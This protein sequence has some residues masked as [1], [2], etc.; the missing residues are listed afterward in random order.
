[1][2]LRVARKT[3]GSLLRGA[4]AAEFDLAALDSTDDR[5]QHHGQVGAHPAGP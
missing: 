4:P 3:F 2:T 1:M 5:H